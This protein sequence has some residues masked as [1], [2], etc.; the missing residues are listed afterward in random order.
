MKE[1]GKV[2]KNLETAMRIY[3]NQPDYNLAMGQC[4]MEMGKVEEVVQYFGNVVRN[5]TKNVNGWIELKCLYKTNCF[6]DGAEYG[7][8][9]GHDE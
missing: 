9:P 8:C 6:E 7:T 1:S 3:R 2:P 4:Y 5:K